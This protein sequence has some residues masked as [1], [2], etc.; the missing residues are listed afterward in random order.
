MTGS[1]TVTGFPPIADHRARVLILGSL[2]SVASV[3]AHQYYG[4][5]R[6]AF[7][8]IMGALF[9]FEPTLDYPDRCARLREAGVA[10]WDVAAQADRPG[11]LDADIRGASVRPNPLDALLDEC[12]R[13]AR[14]FLNGGTAATLFRRHHPRSTRI[15]Q[16]PATRLPSTSPAHASLRFEQKLQAWT[17]VK[18][19]VQ[20]NP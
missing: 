17:V 5:P 11:S 7:W 13:I 1:P 20:N 10:V 6:N 15:A 4:H 16:L 18:Q 19:A 2:P 3:Q 12:P 14:V 8:P 9:G